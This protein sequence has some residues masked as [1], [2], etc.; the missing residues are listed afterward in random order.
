MR[1]MAGLRKISII[2]LSVM[3]ISLFGGCQNTSE[4]NRTG[5]Q[6]SE[7]STATPAAQNTPTDETT[8]TADTTPTAEITPTTEDTTSGE[9]KEV[10]AEPTKSTEVSSEEDGENKETADM[11]G[12]ENSAPVDQEDIDFA[13]MT[14]MEF[15]S[16][17]SLGWNLGNTMDATGGNKKTATSQETSWGN[18]A[19]TSELMATLKENGF[20][21]VRIPVTWQAFTG[22][23]PEYKINEEFMGRVK[24]IVDYCYENDLYVIINMH[25]EEWYDP[26]T[27]NEDAA[28]LQLTAMWAQIAEVF[29]DYDEHLIFE[30]MNEP[31]LRNTAYEWNGGT[32][33]A[34][35]VINHIN[36]AFV[37]TIREASGKNK[38]R[39]LMLPGYAA[40]GEAAVINDIVLPN[41]D[42]LIVS[43]HA[44]TPYNFA[45]NKSG[46][47]AWNA[48]NAADTRDIDNLMT[49]INDKF[50]SQGIPVIIG[51][52]GAMNKDNDEDRAAWAAYYT[53]QAAKTGVPCVWWDNGAFSGTGELFGL[54][55]RTTYKVRYQNI[56]DA[57]VSA[58]GITQE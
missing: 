32:A 23:G 56:L 33:E 20:S 51:E 40:S 4:N 29:K 31:R 30:C 48:A 57:M 17:F 21:I 11:E 24:E 13:S 53:G 39:F 43:V 45:L 18:P 54:V 15:V 44:Y 7:V 14:A 6:V 9:A 49:R 10:T 3:V 16:N 55:S 37:S 42:R 47:S 58:M 28:T 5:N 36:A 25:H 38:T 19:T 46:T 22:D 27:E 34:R 2:L 52:F 35:A 26:Y 8:P 41:D 1:K 12:E 50:I